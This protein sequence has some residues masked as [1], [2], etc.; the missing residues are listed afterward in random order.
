MSTSKSPRETPIATPPAATI[1]ERIVVADDG[2]AAG[3]AAV[4]WVT[5][6]LG[7]RP[8]GVRVIATVP[9]AD[10]EA[11]VAL[12]WITLDRATAVLHTVVPHAA[13]A[14]EVVTGDPEQS[15]CAEAE[16]A[17]LLVVGLAE[18]E[19]G[20]RDALPVRLAERA[21]CVVVVVPEDWA[22][23]TGRT[24]VG[25]SIDAAS[26]AAIAFAA[27]Q[28]ERES[29]E[30]EL[31]HAWQL[32]VTGEV[33]IP[34]VHDDASIPELQQR[35]LETLATSVRAAGLEVTSTARQGMPAQV[36]TAAAE[37]ADLLVVGRRTRRPL[38]RLLLGSVSRSLVEHPPCPVAVVPQPALPLD[39]V[40]DDPRD[41]T[42]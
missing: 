38:T 33:R 35:A 12:G 32:P 9:R 34:E 3:R 13:V 15:L 2:G 11:A 30:L 7:R 4:R 23:G 42:L 26:D 36:L 14:A 10:D 31:V 1:G 6:R 27:G 5:E 16:N 29:R 20:R 22:P 37:D 19:R 40:H 18:P 21:S 8:A 25:A 17:D 39:V 41:A 28:A 24:V